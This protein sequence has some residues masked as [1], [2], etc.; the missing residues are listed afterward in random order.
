MGSFFYAYHRKLQK[1]RN[2][3]QLILK[4]GWHMAKKKKPNWEKIKAE[5]ITTKT[6]YRKLAEKYG[7]SLSTLE[8][9][10]KRENWQAEKEMIGGEIAVKTEA[11]LRQKLTEKIS[12]KKAAKIVDA[13]NIETQA[14]S[15]LNSVIL[16]T[17]EDEQQFNR[18]LIQ[19]KEK[20][21]NHTG[22]TKDNPATDESTESWW[23]EEKIFDT[24]DTKRL[25]DLA[26]ALNIVSTLRR[27]LE[28]IL[29]EAVKQKLEIER[30]RLDMDKAKSGVFDDPD[31]E[32]QTGIVKMPAVDVETYEKEK[33][34]ELERL[35]AEKKAGGS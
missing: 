27:E 6:S 12:E 10:G 21:Y 29:P 13:L 14:I 2:D 8:K 32:N 33:A 19:R 20:T 9:R 11:K 26:A 22:K 31:E 30:E 18:H 3:I 28:G 4:G 24:V 16:K 5:Y 23:V 17:L 1:H 25:K 34:A 35:I 15:L 7:I